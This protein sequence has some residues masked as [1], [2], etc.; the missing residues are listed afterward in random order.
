[1]K[2]TG[3]GTKHLTAEQKQLI[4]EHFAMRRD[5]VAAANDIGVTKEQV[6]H[7]LK[8]N[9]I[10]PPNC[11]NGLCYQ[12]IDEVRAWAAEGLSLSEM[13][14]R[15]G[16]NHHRVDEFLKK[17]SIPRTPFR[18]T[19]ENNPAWKGGRMIDKDGYSLVLRPD[20]PAASIHGYVREHRLVMEAVLGRELTAQEVVH[21]KNEN[22]L[23]NRPDNLVLYASNADHLAET[24]KGKVPNWTPEGRA[25]TLAG[26]RRRGRKRRTASPSASAPGGPPSPETTGPTPA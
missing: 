2:N 9:G 14:R 20:H 26:A 4:L 5:V 21:H 8:K 1:M 22:K 18:Q 7:W 16:T 19:G 6:R 11:R 25:A 13:A 17:H 15:L 12:R 23:D 24:L 3:L 10:R